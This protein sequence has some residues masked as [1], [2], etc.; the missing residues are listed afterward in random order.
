MKRQGVFDLSPS[1]GRILLAELRNEGTSAYHLFVR[2]AFSEDDAQTLS[3]VI[4][5][6]PTGMSSLSK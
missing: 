2:K 1:Q 6:K 3:A 5:I 4:L